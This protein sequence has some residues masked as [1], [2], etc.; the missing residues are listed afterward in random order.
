MK[1]IIGALLPAIILMGYI[2]KKDTLEKESPGILLKCLL[3]G[4]LAAL[5]AIILEAILE[6]I[7][8]L[9]FSGLL[10]T[11]ASN[12]VGVALVEEAAKL[13]FCWLFVWKS[14]EFNYRF[15]GVVY[16]AFTSLGFAA[17]E[18]VLYAVSY[19][20]GVLFSRAIFT[21]PAHLS[22][23]IFL[24]SYFGTAKMYAVRGHKGKAQNLVMYGL[25]QSVLLH[26]FYDFCLTVGSL[27]LTL[28]FYVF[29]ILMDILTIRRIR[30]D[31]EA[32]SPIYG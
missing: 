9:T 31:S 11:L 8:S 18:N 24:G 17:F 10:Y 26:G 23:A 29:V 20:T 27:W 16:M 25:L 30:R 13:F 28:A 1:L 6:G 21:I 32:D 14:R 5:A 2:Y 12:F 4:C 3:G 19:G 22:F 15:D 7:F